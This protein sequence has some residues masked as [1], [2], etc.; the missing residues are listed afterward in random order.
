MKKEISI[1]FYVNAI[2]I[3]LLIAC[4]YIFYTDRQART[5]ATPVTTPVPASS[6]TTNLPPEESQN[7]TQAGPVSYA[8]AVNKAANA[9]VSIYTAKT[10]QRK[11]STGNPFFDQFLGQQL[12]EPVIQTGSGSGV[13]FNNDG[14]IITNYHVIKDAQQMRVLL[15][16]GRD[17]PATVVGS[18]PE[19]DLAVLRIIAD[20]LTPI[21]LSEMET[22]AIGDVALAIGNPFG[23]GQTVTMGI[24]SATGRDR[25]GLNTFENFIQTDAAIN[26]GNS[27]G[28]LINANGH[29]IGINTAIFSR[30]GGSNGIGFAIPANMAKDVLEQILENGQVQRGWLGVEAVNM[31]PTIRARIGI[32]GIV[33]T[34]IYRD[35]PADT[36]GLV[37]GD[38]ITNINGIDI[39]SIHDVLKIITPNNPGDTVTINGIRNG[40]QFETNATL[41]QRPLSS[42]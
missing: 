1:L 26:P 41:A 9:V 32:N 27:G 38:I 24:I 36:A 15:K 2:L 28:A 16:D 25:V 12:S 6:S 30:S 33:V 37:P 21:V 18:D 5:E 7:T 42:S 13:I 8:N 4:L 20:K 35:G 17:Y 31:S 14:Y 10:V 19:T 39:T 34:G 22:I 29:L 40:T 11:Q 23:V 3:G